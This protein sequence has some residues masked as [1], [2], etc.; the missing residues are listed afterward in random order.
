MSHSK[1]PSEM[2]SLFSLK[3]RRPRSQI[4]KS[5]ESDVECFRIGPNQFLS[6]N[7]DG[8]SEEITQGLY[9]DPKFIGKILAT[10]CLSDLH[11]AGVKPTGFLL[12]TQWKSGT[13]RSFKR[14]LIEGC[15]SI[16]NQVGIAIEGGDSG[17]GAAECFNAFAFGLSDKAPLSRIGAKAGDFL[18]LLG[19][20]N[21]GHLPA[22]SMDY[23]F[24][25]NKKPLSTRAKFVGQEINKS[26]KFDQIARWRPYAKASIDTSDGIFN[27]VYLLSYLNKLGFDMAFSSESLSPTAKRFFQ[28]NNWPIEMTWVNDL[29]DLN[30]LVVVAPKDR[31]NF[32]KKNAAICIGRFTRDTGRFNFRSENTD[33]SRAIPLSRAAK[34]PRDVSEIRKSLL[35]WAKLF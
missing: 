31:E 28:K 32:L 13:A 3:I 14:S 1:I 4:F 27:S 16:L 19:T 8:I 29:G 9:A 21:V 26:L 12:S 7:C 5:F 33:L 20:E 6:M 25:K 2:Q 34:Q 17:S 23:L 10:S 15:E 11:C 18:F 22:C 35:S 24:N 30:T